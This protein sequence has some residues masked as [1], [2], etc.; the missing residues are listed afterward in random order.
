[1]PEPGRKRGRERVYDAEKTREA[2]LNAAE[3][4]F[5]ENGFDGTAVDVIAAQS[6][7]NK[8]LIFQYFGDK[9]SLYTHVLKRVDREMGALMA[10]VF[11]PLLE[12]E[13]AL[14]EA[15]QLKALLETVVQVLFDYLIDH[16]LLVRILTWEMAEGWQTFRQI[17]SQ[18][19]PEDME[20]F[21]IFF[22]RAQDAGL[23]RSDFV[24][25]IQLSLVIQMCQMYLTYLPLY[26]QLLPGEDLSSSDAF[27]RARKYLVAF[28]VAG[29]MI[30]LPETKNEKGN[31]PV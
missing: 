12:E 24:P 2:I 27:V 5:A 14:F 19:P 10:R 25:I 3:A 9:L 23:L 1:M 8:S 29:M 21:G 28:V 22:R 6:G 20:R 4:V 30:D 13:T 15:Y 16:S 17:S 11:A 18:F 31:E 7:Y 26:Q